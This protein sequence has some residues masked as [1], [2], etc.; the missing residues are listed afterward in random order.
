MQNEKIAAVKSD[1]QSLLPCLSDA[2]HKSVL[3]QLQALLGVCQNRLSPPPVKS[4]PNSSPLVAEQ[5]GWDWPL[6][7]SGIFEGMEDTSLEAATQTD[8][9]RLES[10]STADAATETYSFQTVERQVQVD[11]ASAAVLERCVQ[12][13]PGHFS[14][15]QFCQ[16]EVVSLVEEQTDAEVRMDSLE[17]S[18]AIGVEVGVEADVET[19]DQGVQWMR[20][21]PE[22]TDVTCQTEEDVISLKDFRD[23]EDYYV[24]QIELLQKEKCGLRKHS[25]T[26]RDELTHRL[27]QMSVQLQ[28]LQERESQFE[29]VL[30]KHRQLYDRELE[31]ARQSATDQLSNLKECLQLVWHEIKDC[32]ADGHAPASCTDDDSVLEFTQHLINAVQRVCAELGQLRGKVLDLADMEKAFQTTLQQADGLVSHIEQ[33]HLQRIRELELSENELRTQLE[34]QQQQQPP[35]QGQPQAAAV[36]VYSPTE[37]TE[38]LESKIKGNPAPQW[39]ATRRAAHLPLSSRFL[40]CRLSLSVTT[41]ARK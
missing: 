35:Q 27:E 14:R 2:S 38:Y 5:S 3:D 26:D 15:D 18:V 31:L 37:V 32:V 29:Q 13:E 23:I 12:T 34:Q 11:A 6:Q 17:D 20:F 10:P 24:Q 8:A 7:E 25:Q 22:P 36:A 40:T 4:T 30:L 28:E 19:R 21:E 39:S 16:Y 1:L 33:R 41:R 9:V